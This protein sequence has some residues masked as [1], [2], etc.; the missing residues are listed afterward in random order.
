MNGKVPSGNCVE[1]RRALVSATSR[2]LRLRGPLRAARRAEQP[3]D[4]HAFHLFQAAVEALAHLV[5]GALQRF[6]VLFRSRLDRLQR[7]LAGRR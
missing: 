6:L 2:H 4:H 7:L 1:V 3:F 5:E